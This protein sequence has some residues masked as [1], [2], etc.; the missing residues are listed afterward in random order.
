LPDE[1]EEISEG[2]SRR[3]RIRFGIVGR[4]CEADVAVFRVLAFEEAGFVA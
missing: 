2:P 4:V 3:Y 1:Y